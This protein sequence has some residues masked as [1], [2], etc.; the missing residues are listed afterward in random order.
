MAILKSKTQE[1]EGK[2]VVMAFG[3]FDFFHA[4]HEYFLKQA[5]ELGDYLIVVISRDRTVQQI[6]GKT[7]VNS[8]HKRLK[9]IRETS[10]ADK[11]IL[12][13]HDDKHKVIRKYRPD[14]ITLGYDQFVFTQKLKKT[15]I[16][17]QLNT[18]IK[19]LD[20]HFP[21]VYKSSILRNKQREQEQTSPIQVNT[22]HQNI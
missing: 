12:G 10:I 14:I 20:A 2:K 5:K 6:K 21:L 9:T 11:V 8:E 7:A 22:A 4:G 17:L 15:L 19:R 18:V 13:Y 1:T 16:D 3:T